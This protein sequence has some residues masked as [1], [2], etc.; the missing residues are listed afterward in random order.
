MSKHVGEKCGKQ[1]I[2]YILSSQRGITPSKIDAKW[3]HSNLLC[4]TLKQI[5]SYPPVDDRAGTWNTAMNAACVLHITWQLYLIS[6]V[7]SIV[8]HCYQGRPHHLAQ[9]TSLWRHDFSPIRRALPIDVA[10]SEIYFVHY[11][12]KRSF[13]ASLASFCGLFFQF[14]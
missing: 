4:S 7:T 1:C 12:V 13:N 14:E 6:H 5:L 10:L 8:F 11:L 2:S 3:Q 9:L